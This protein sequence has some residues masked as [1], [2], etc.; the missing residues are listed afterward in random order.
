MSENEAGVTKSGTKRPFIIICSEKFQGGVYHEKIG[1]LLSKKTIEQ[2]SY[3]F[4]L[5]VNVKMDA[6]I[7]K[8]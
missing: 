5:T 6:E 1:I 3:R 4:S 7:Q 2:E 8:M